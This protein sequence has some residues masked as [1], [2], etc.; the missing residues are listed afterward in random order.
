MRKPWT[1]KDIM[2]YFNKSSAEI[3][4][5][6]KDGLKCTPLNEG[7]VYKYEDIVEYLMED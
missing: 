7:Y 2:F 6:R 3:S 4:R 5:W 1:T